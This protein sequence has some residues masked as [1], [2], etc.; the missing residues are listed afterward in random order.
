MSIKDYKWNVAFKSLA[1]AFISYTFVFVLYSIVEVT[2]KKS[3]FAFATEILDKQKQ[4]LVYTSLFVNTVF[5]IDGVVLKKIYS[6]SDKYG[7]DTYVY[8]LS[9]TA[10]KYEGNEEIVI[11]SMIYAFGN[12]NSFIDNENSLI[13]YRSYESGGK[14]ISF[15]DLGDFG[16]DQSMFSKERCLQYNLCSLYATKESLSDR[17]LVSTTYDDYRTGSKTI[18]LSSPITDNGKVI[19]DIS[20][21]IYFDIS[22]L[23][24]EASISSQTQGGM[25]YINV[26]YPQY[27]MGELSFRS[28]YVVDNKSTLVFELPITKLILDTAPIFLLSLAISLIATIHYM[29]YTI[30]KKMFS[31]VYEESNR[32]EMTGLCN[33]KVFSTPEFLSDTLNQTVA[34]LA[35]DGNKLKQINDTYGHH[36]GDAAIKH[37]ADAMKKVFRDSDY[38]V[39]TGGD[40]FLAILPGCPSPRVMELKE[41][42]KKEVMRK[43]IRP[44]NL[45]VSV[46]VGIAFKRPEEDLE[47]A[48]IAADENLYS[49][50]ADSREASA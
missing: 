5:H 35:I 3:K 27:P 2:D 46:S 1:L 11:S 38:I 25:N 40:E 37:I 23:A 21:D 12:M 4:R 22:I 33:R 6:E 42:L 30:Q 9:G 17:L 19:G 7:L 49:D 26:D 45:E 31:Q 39:R 8:S 29:R 28:S 47:Y 41:Q 50:K 15:N 20:T 32:D 44:H 48:L 16:V 36:C 24:D 13:Y 34:I 18:T 14:I 10:S 43:K